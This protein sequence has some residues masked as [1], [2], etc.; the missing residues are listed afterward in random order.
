MR[1]RIA[2]TFKAGAVGF[3]GALAGA[4]FPGLARRTG[5]HRITNAFAP[6]RFGTSLMAIGALRVGTRSGLAVA[7]AGY[8]RTE[9][10]PAASV[11]ITAIAA[12]LS[13]GAGRLRAGASGT[14]GIFR[15]FRQS[16]IANR[17]G[18]TYYIAETVADASGAAKARRLITGGKAENF[19]IAFFIS[20]RSASFLIIQAY[21]IAVVHHAAG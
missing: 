9:T 2:R 18:R 19:L 7:P 20:D 4:E 10:F 21:I 1:I 6:S 8:R 11:Q 17:F 15:L 14:R 13:R 5:I 16:Y 3:T 12:G